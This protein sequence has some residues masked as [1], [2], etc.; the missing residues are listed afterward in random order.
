MLRTNTRLPARPSFTLIE[1]LVVIAIIAI[2]I[3]LTSAAVMKVRIVAVRTQTTNDITKMQD[4]LQAAMKR[5]GDAPVLPSRLLL[6]NDLSKYKTDT[7]VLSKRSSDTLRKMFGR[8]LLE[9][10]TFVYWDGTTNNAGVSTLEGHQC[11]IFYLGGAT[12]P[13]GT[14]RGCLGFSTDPLNPMR[15]G[16]ERLGPFFEG[17]KSNRLVGTTFFSYLDPYRDP[18]DPL[19]KPYAYFSSTTAANSYNPYSVV[20][21]AKPSGMDYVSDCPSLGLF[22][23]V[24]SVDTSTK[25]WNV[26]FVNPNSYQII[27][28]GADGKFGPGW[29]P[30]TGAMPW[31]PT[32]G[33]SDADTRDNQANF[34]KSLLTG[35]QSN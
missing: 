35:P 5:Y 32:G 16:G 1:L 6:Y 18:L 23:Y 3:G 19:A 22:P 13:T 9:Y 25:P 26:Q 14:T 24:A 33:A 30:T 29:D 34:S 10:G 20:N 15:A 7:S 28:A 12:T 2:L 21:N 11:L 4:G 8:R 31:S 27:S 17:F